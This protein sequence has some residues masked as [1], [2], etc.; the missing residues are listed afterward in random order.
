[1]YA[2]EALRQLEST[3]RYVEC[4]RLLEVCFCAALRV[5]TARAYISSLSAFSQLVH[6][7]RACSIDSASVDD[8]RLCVT[9]L[10]CLLTRVLYTTLPFAV[11]RKFEASLEHYYDEIS[12]LHGIQRA[13]FK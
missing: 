12:R 8:H 7:S 11:P 4:P 10:H 6:K 1:M 5:V 2:A 13:S 9:Y 3:K